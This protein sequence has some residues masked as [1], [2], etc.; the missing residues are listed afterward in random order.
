[1]RL[2]PECNHKVTGNGYEALNGCEAEISMKVKVK[3]KVVNLYSASSC[4]HVRL[5][6]LTRAIDC[7]AA[8]C[9]LQ[10]QAGAPAGQA[11]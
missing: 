2:I 4:T 8:V 11:A 7:I 10:T 9:S 3:V 5:S 1:M 6:S